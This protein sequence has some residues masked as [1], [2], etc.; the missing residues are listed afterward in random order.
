[1]QQATLNAAYL[2]DSSMIIRVIIASDDDDTHLP[3]VFKWEL[4]YRRLITHDRRNT[5]S[6]CGAFEARDDGSPLPPTAPRFSNP[7]TY[8]QAHKSTQRDMA[9][10]FCN[11][12]SDRLVLQI[13]RFFLQFADF[14]FFAII[15]QSIAMLRKAQ[16]DGRWLGTWGGVCIPPELFAVRAASISTPFLAVRSTMKDT[17]TTELRLYAIPICRSTL[18]VGL[19]LF[20]PPT[21]RLV[22]EE[23]KF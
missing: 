19:S 3:Q 4:L 20:F 22:S 14:V 13:L 15:A 23:I 1:M 21:T 9:F 7:I 12:Y 8:T 2:R 16:K 18:F 5:H 17:R 11:L 10:P 6:P